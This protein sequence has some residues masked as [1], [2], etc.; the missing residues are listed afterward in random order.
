[1]ASIADTSYRRIC[2]E[3]GAAYVV[4][5]LASAKGISY[6]DKGSAVLLTVRDYERPMAVQLFGSEPEFMV[7]AAQ[8]ALDYHPDIID[9]N[10]GCPVPKV[11]SGGGGSALMIT[12]ELAYDITRSGLVNIDHYTHHL[13]FESSAMIL[14]LITFGKYLEARSKQK[15]TDSISKLMEL[16]PKTAILIQD[17]QEIEVAIEDIK[18]NDCIRIKEGKSRRNLI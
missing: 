1:M 12:P 7:K 6:G 11:V 14:T 9:L 13:Y 18:V 17:E 3:F 15:T 5:E 10:M 4:G 8:I 16:S 2:K